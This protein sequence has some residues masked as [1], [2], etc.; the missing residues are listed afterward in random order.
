MLINLDAPITITPAIFSGMVVVA[1]TTGHVAGYALRADGC[2]PLLEVFSEN[3][4]DTQ[5]WVLP[6]DAQ[7][8]EQDYYRVHTSLGE[9]YGIRVNPSVI[10]ISDSNGRG[11]LNVSLEGL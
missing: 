6:T 2:P 3:P 8:F 5:S 10:Q 1:Y 7:D 11:L 9:L 4:G